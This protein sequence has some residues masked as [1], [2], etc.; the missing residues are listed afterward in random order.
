MELYCTP[1]N[2][3]HLFAAAASLSAGVYED[4]EIIDMAGDEH[5][6]VYG[7]VLD[8]TLQGKDRLN[9]NWQ[10]NSILQ[11]V[12]GKSAQD[13]SK[14][15]YWIDCGDDDFLIRGNCI[16]HLALSEKKVPHEFRM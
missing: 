3:P 11:L 15:R 16:L 5:K 2:Y 7:Q 8:T 6:Q 10:N 12:K 9:K 1:L 13:L 4:Q 14:V